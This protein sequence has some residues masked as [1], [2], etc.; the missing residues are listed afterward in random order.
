MLPETT[1]TAHDLAGAGLGQA[2]GELHLVR[3]GDGADDLAHVHDELLLEIVAGLH[4]VVEGHVSVDAD[5]LD[6][7][8]VADHGGLGHLGM[9]DQRAF[10]VRRADAVTGDVEA[11]SYTH[12]TLPKNR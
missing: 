10:D 5:A 2:G 6:G 8:R 11:V 7:V 4:A 12:L 1:R 9:A 3:R